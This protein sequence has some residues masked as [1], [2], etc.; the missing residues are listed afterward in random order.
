[1]YS[2]ENLQRQQGIALIGA[3]NSGKTTLY[4]WLTGSKFKTVNYPGA[5]VE[6]SLGKLAPHL[7]IGPMVMDTP[8]TYSLH[9]KS[10]DEVVTLKALYQNP[11]L[12][13][14]SGI[15]IVV[16]G[17]QLNRHLLLAEQ[18]QEAGFPMV[19][20]VTMADLLSKEGFN[21]DV[22]FLSN[23]YQ[24]KV[25]LFDGLL[26]GGLLEVV[27]AIRQL[28]LKKSPTKPINW[29]FNE[30]ES[31]IEEI[32]LAANRALAGAG[33]EVPHFKEGQIGEK[34]KSIS[35]RSLKI[36]SWLLHPFFGFIFF[37]VIM[38]FLFSSIFWVA[39]PFMELVDSF[40]SLTVKYVVGLAPD[41]LWS[42]FLGNGIIASFGAALIFVPQIFILFFGIG[43]LEGSGY[44]ARAAT[45]IDKP[46][47]LIGMSGRSFVP[48]L[49]G[50]ACAVPAMISTRNISSSRDRWITT[51]ILPLMTCSARLPVYALLLAFIFRNEASWKP[52]LVLALLYLGSILVG[53]IV[54]GVLNKFLAKKDNSFFMMEHPLY[55]RPRWDV[56]FRQAFNRTMSYVKRA[57]PAIFVFAVLVWVTSTFPHYN[58]KDPQVRLSQSY[59][60]QVGVIL[61]P[62]MEPIGSDW[63][64]GIGLLSAFAARE[65]FVSSLAIVF[66]ITAEDEVQQKVGLLDQMTLAVDKNGHSVFTVASV[67]ALI[68]FFMI[69]L[70]CMSTF[71]VAMKEMASWKFAVS[72]LVSFNLIA[73]VLAVLVYR[74]M[75]SLGF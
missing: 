69:A 66:N 2:G 12:G 53:A 26:G 71:A 7:G 72:Q 45:I 29:N 23:R 62:I 54:A 58:E 51:F 19:L 21:L 1:M 4:N 40:F 73:Y 43:L 39:A 61:E 3:P 42:D 56:L 9:P 15:V 32:E 70:Q 75:H 5:T 64:V 60:G 48:I 20:A 47:S 27:A 16:D 14:V 57:G 33:T 52:G 38:G 59:L 44:L 41:E 31:K 49:S 63:R 50:F 25:L 74:T 18:V 35:E 28:D 65:V 13:V 24:C 8:G 68:V 55:R 6:Y 11:Q 30:C 34:L 17:T 67:S 10:A 36:D 37:I 22:E 46:F